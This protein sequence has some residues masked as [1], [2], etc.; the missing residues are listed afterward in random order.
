MD[1]FS[2]RHHADFIYEIILYSSCPLQ[3]IL[4]LGVD[5]KTK[6]IYISLPSFCCRDILKGVDHHI[7]T[8]NHCLGT[9]YPQR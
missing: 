5:N 7:L 3:N 9:I 2:L 6:R 4:K 8:I 1:F